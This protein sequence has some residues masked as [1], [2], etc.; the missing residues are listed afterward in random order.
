MANID[1]SAPAASVALSS[2]FSFLN[3]PKNSISWIAFRSASKIAFVYLNQL[4]LILN[5]FD[6]FII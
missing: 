5:I 2:V 3:C 6:R 1:W 4:L